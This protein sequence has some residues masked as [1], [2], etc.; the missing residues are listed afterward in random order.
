M[1][2]SFKKHGYIKW[3]G[4]NS[5]KWDR[6]CYS[7]NRRRKYKSICK[8]CTNFPFDFLTED[9]NLEQIPSDRIVKNAVD[10]S[11]SNSDKYC[12]SSDGGSYFSDDISSLRKEFNKEI[13][14]IDKRNVK[15][16]SWE[17]YLSNREK[18]LNKD[19]P[20]YTIVLK[21]VVVEKV[22]W[23]F[24]MPWDS[25]FA[26]KR[27]EE[28]KYITLDHK[29]TERDIPE[30][31]EL[32]RFWKQK[33]HYSFGNWFLMDYVFED[34]LIPLNFKTSDEMIDWFRE[35]QEDILKKWLKARLLRK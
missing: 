11:V 29:P 17:D 18:V 15:R 22:N 7:R 33:K 6:T 14:G 13:F 28:K 21:R 3:C 5:D 31:W 32:V 4:E 8:E 23:G 19:K 30:G 16:N 1:S 35:N 12:W 20:L 10:Y 24:Y 2:R 9:D 26:G 34:N 25:E 27:K